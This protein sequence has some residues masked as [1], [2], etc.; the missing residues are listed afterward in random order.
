[1]KRETLIIIGVVLVAL[2]IGVVVF[3]SGRGGVPN[4]SSAVANTQPSA[5]I[6][7]FTEIT[8]GSESTVATRVNYVIT[9]AD[10]LN[11][12]WEMV[13]ATGTP[14]TI[15]FRTQAVIAVF[16]GQKSTGGYSIA[17]ASVTDTGD[18]RTVAVTLTSPGTDCMVTESF[19]NPYQ[20]VTVPVS[21]ASLAHTDTEVS[22]ACN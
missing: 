21:N 18:T 15:D 7:P 8:R 14:P 10:E 3:F 5:V 13:N 4:T 22:K 11:K 2:I 17:V 16:A 1:M 6:V 12:L 9:S 19:T 20:I